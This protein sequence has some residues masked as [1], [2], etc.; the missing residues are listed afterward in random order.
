M[1]LLFFSHSGKISIPICD[2]ISVCYPKRKNSSS[3]SLPQS[4]SLSTPPQQQQHVYPVV[5]GQSPSLNGTENNNSFNDADDCRCFTINYA[6]RNIDPKVQDS[7]NQG[8]KK[9]CQNINV[10]RVHSITLHNN[11]KFIIRE[12]HDTL[13]KILNCK[14]ISFYIEC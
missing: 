1:L 5:N 10:W 9:A 2:V 13:L 7:G 6:K 8:S 3:S 12:W 14:L 4:P 11:D